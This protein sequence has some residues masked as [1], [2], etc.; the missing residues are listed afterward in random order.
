[1]NF[2]AH[3]HLS[4]GDRELIIGNLIADA[5]K[6]NK[7]KAL[8]DGIAKGVLLHRHI[9]S[10]TDTS[11]QTINL[12]RILSPSLGRY[13]PVAIDVY[14]D[15]FL[16]LQWDNFHHQSLQEYVGHVHNHLESSLHELDPE[17]RDFIEKLLRYK[18]LLAYG[19]KN[20]LAIIFKQMSIRFNVE[21]LSKAME[22]LE[23]HYEDIR[24]CFS[25]LYPNLEKSALNFT[26]L[27]KL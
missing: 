24:N 12:K 4:R 21:I 14:Y 2:L 11:P 20:S 17:S 27:D 19:D 25:E 5:Y 8:P 22:S 18:W 23:S 7:Y 13:A 1:M 15:H 16:S 10:F 6:G 26:A 3:V 9:D